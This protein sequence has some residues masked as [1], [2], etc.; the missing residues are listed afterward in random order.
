MFPKR[1]VKSF[2]Y[3]LL[4]TFCFP[5]KKIVDLNKKYLIEKV[6]FFHILTDT[7]SAALK[8]IFISD[9]NSQLPEEKFTD[10]TLEVL[11]TS[12]IYKRFDT[13]HD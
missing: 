3:D 6:E 11:V 13:S 5:Q 7:H 2:I 8:F 12:K 4:E 10:V 9:P 1:Y